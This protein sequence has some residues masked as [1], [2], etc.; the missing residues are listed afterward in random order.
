M[1]VLNPTGNKLTDNTPKL[2]LCT[3]K[4]NPKTQAPEA[5]SESNPTGNKLTDKALVQ[6]ITFA[7]RRQVLRVS[8]GERVSERE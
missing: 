7:L 8:E 2:N 6:T 5:M 3:T 4:L 1:S